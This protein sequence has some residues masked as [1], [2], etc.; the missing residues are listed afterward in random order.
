MIINTV[1]SLVELLNCSTKE[2]YKTI[3]ASLDIDPMSF[4]KFT[5][6]NS[7]FYTRNC[8]S[9]TANYELILLCWE[10]GQKTPVHCHGGEECW[11]NIIQGTL[12][13]TNFTF[14]NKTLLAGEVDHLLPGEVSYMNDELGFHMLEN[15]TAQ[16]AMSLHLYMDPISHCSR[17]DEKSNAFISVEMSD[18][19]FEGKLVVSPEM[20]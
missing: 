3:G 9:R 5:H 17:Y 7:G 15:D 16:R 14:E 6:W 18:Y 2:E 10:K 19:S 4:S 12:K 8:I 13:E 1:K 11:V 20:V